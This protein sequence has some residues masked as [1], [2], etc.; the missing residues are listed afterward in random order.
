M[1]ELA[2]RRLGD[3]LGGDAEP[4][5]EILVGRARPE[6]GHADEEAV[7]ADD[8]VPS[9]TYRRLDRDAQGRIPDDRLPHVRG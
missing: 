6:A 2:Q 4:A 7:A 1:D 8:R 5:I 9:L 3:R